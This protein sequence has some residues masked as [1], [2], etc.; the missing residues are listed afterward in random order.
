MQ[1]QGG[2]QVDM[3]QVPQYQYNPSISPKANREAAAKFNENLQQ[4]IKNAKGAYQAISLAAPILQSGKPSSGG[5][6]SMVTRGREWVFG[7]GGEASEADSELGVLGGALTGM[8]PRFEGPQGVLDVKIYEQMA[9]RVSDS[10][11]PTSSRMKALNTMIDLHKKYDP[12]QDW[13][14]LKKQLTTKPKNSKVALGAAPAAPKIG[15]VE[16]GYVFK[17]GNPADPKNW[18]PK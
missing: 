7:E 15:T 8:Q 13:D 3:S 1:P 18:S 6:Q 5:L 16:D 10:N 17:G 14:S 12:T 4:N 2:Q 9:G 11:V